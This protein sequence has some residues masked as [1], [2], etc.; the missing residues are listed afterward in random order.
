MAEQNFVH[1]TDKN[2]NFLA[3]RVHMARYLH[4]YKEHE[5]V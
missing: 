4:H 3:F 5:N 1:G 2:Q